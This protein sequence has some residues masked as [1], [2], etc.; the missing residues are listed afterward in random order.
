M[1]LLV[2]EREIMQVSVAMEFCNIEAYKRNKE[3][4]LLHCHFS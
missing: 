3:I 2:K 1:L 4:K